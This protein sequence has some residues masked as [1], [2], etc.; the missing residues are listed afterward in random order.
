MFSNVLGVGI[1]MYQRKLLEPSLMSDPPILKK[2]KKK[3]CCVCL[4]FQGADQR[5][6]IPPK[7]FSDPGTWRPSFIL[8]KLFGMRRSL[9]Q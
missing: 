8:K 7:L 1:S 9:D 5:S 4:L 2:S 3:N 6:E